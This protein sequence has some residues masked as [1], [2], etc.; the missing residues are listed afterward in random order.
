M[1]HS[2]HH[3]VVF[4][5]VILLAV[6]TA[7]G[8][9]DGGG[10]LAEA[11]ARHMGGRPASH[12]DSVRAD[13]QCNALAWDILHEDSGIRLASPLAAGC[14]ASLCLSRD[15]E[16]KMLYHKLLLTDAYRGSREEP[17]PWTVFLPEMRLTLDGKTWNAAGKD[18]RHEARD[19]YFTAVGKGDSVAHDTEIRFQALW[20]TPFEKRWTFPEVFH[21][22]GGDTVRLPMMHSSVRM[23]YA[24]MRDFAAVRLPLTGELTFIVV[25]PDS[26]MALN[27]VAGRLDRM[28]WHRLCQRF[29]RYDTVYFKMPKIYETAD[30]D[31]TG[32]IRRMND[33]A[34]G[35]GF[36]LRKVTQRISMTAEE[37]EAP[38]RYISPEEAKKQQQ[39]KR[40]LSERIRKRMV[41]RTAPFY[42]DRPFLYFV[43]DKYGA[44][45]LMGRME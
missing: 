11:A 3:T 39:K 23:E 5:L 19:Y 4:P 8:C 45:C 6:M 17:R 16:D 38:V 28:T 24:R 25:L 31:A 7:A 13:R 40:R 42:A 43:T 21:R 34:T 15:G 33:G 41:F 35:T 12:E 37:A 30:Y 2:L 14:A 9:D 10:R 20:L 32:A 22:S 29:E 1:R 18:F 44:I 36:A 27:D 26:G